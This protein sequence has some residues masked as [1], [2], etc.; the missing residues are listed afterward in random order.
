LRPVIIVMNIFY[1]LKKS[2]NREKER[3]EWLRERERIDLIITVLTPTCLHVVFYTLH[4]LSI[5][6]SLLIFLYLFH[7]FLSFTFSL[8]SSCLS[9][10]SLDNFHPWSFF[11]RTHQSSLSWSI[12]HP[13]NHSPLTFYPSS[14]ISIL[15]A[16][17]NLYFFPFFISTA[18]LQLLFLFSSK[19][20]YNALLEEACD[21]EVFRIFMNIVINL[22]QLFVWITRTICLITL[23]IGTYLVGT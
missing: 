5:N 15:Y 3:N 11:L 20:I 4:T 12:H 18:H 22:L 8:N 21:P 19:I 6:H 1:F 17:T 2:K 14:I 16:L 9:S 23:Q 7:S 13:H 10:F